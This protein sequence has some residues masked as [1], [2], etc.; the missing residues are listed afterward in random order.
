MH[1]T[2]QGIPSAEGEIATAMTNSL[3]HGGEDEVEE[4]D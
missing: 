3:S 1:Q 4:P 2:Q